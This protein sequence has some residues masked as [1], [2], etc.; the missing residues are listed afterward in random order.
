MIKQQHVYTVSGVNPNI[1]RVGGA[2]EPSKA[3]R[4]VVCENFLI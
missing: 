2:I 1:F 3:P 4:E